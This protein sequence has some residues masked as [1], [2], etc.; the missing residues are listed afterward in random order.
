MNDE[1]RSIFLCPDCGSASTATD[2]GDVACSACN[3]RFPLPKYL[4]KKADASQAQ[5]V[6]PQA[7]PAQV[8]AP[9]AQAKPS[10]EPRMAISSGPKSGVIQRNVAQRSRG[11]LIPKNEMDQPATPVPVLANGDVESLQKERG[12]RRRRMKKQARP[13]PR[14]LMG[15]FMVWVVAVTVILLIVSALQGFFSGKEG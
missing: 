8:V 14:K 5:A 6:Q 2:E 13:S 3:K 7:A 12:E 10:I 9:P 4:Q 11:P 1:A 15:W